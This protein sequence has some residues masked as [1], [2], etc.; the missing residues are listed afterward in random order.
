MRMV[1]CF[2]SHWLVEL[3]RVELAVLLFES[4]V[5]ARLR[6][7]LHRLGLVAVDLREALRHQR[8]VRAPHAAAAANVQLVRARVVLLLEDHVE[9]DVPVEVKG[10]VVAVVVH[11]EPAAALGVDDLADGVLVRRR[12]AVVHILRVCGHVRERAAHE[13]PQPGEVAAGAHAGKTN[14]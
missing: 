12:E 11:L 13:Q 14:A 7:G 4:R 9:V 5:V 1:K 8:V 6:E 3:A 2:W 10:V